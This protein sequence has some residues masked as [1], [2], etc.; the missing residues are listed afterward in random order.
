MET[1]RRLLKRDA[2]NEAQRQSIRRTMQVLAGMEAK[3]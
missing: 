1:V 2:D 3:F